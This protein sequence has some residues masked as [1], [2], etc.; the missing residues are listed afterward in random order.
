MTRDSFY[1]ITWGVFS[2]LF[3]F[4]F[5]L[6]F[7]FNNCQL[8]LGNHALSQRLNFRQ[9][10]ASL[11]I[12]R[13]LTPDRLLP[14]RSKFKLL[15]PSLHEIT[16]ISLKRTLQNRIKSSNSR[17]SNKTLCLKINPKAGVGLG[18]QMLYTLGVLYRAYQHNY[19]VEI[20]N[21]H[22]NGVEL[23][24]Q[25]VYNINV[26]QITCITDDVCDRIS[27][28]NRNL[29][30]HRS[31]ETQLHFID[32]DQEHRKDWWFDTCECE[33]DDCKACP[34]MNDFIK[35]G[36]IFQEWSPYLKNRK[37][38][39]TETSACFQLRVSDN[40]EGDLR[41]DEHV[42][43]VFDARLFSAF[44]YNKTVWQFIPGEHIG[45]NSMK[46]QLEKSLF[47]LGT[48]DPIYIMSNRN[49]VPVL[50]KWFPEYGRRFLHL[51]DFLIDSGTLNDFQLVH[52]DALI[53]AQAGHFYM[54][55]STLGKQVGWMRKLEEIT[56]LMFD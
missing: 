31:V 34:G 27:C 12:P 18:N 38:I 44:H 30:L 11:R 1:Y 14:Q 21:F 40:Y 54:P 20:S 7:V 5:C 37:L 25:S 35:G 36:N 10:T 16:E 19:S 23:S 26:S 24:S 51:G 49:F 28:L 43:D 50:E 8:R 33:W 39:Q 52:L 6:Y 32:T 22:R 56:Q 55:Q 29:M 46:C 47:E 13:H 48:H 2:P 53:C 42:R 45:W 3:I 9:H 17:H 4:A 15:P 41:M